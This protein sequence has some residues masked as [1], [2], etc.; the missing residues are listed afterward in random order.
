MSFAEFVLKKELS[1]FTLQLANPRNVTTSE[2][3]MN[4]KMKQ[5]YEIIEL[6]INAFVQFS[7]FFRSF[8]L[9]YKFLKEDLRIFNDSAFH[10]CVNIEP[11]RKVQNRTYLFLL[12][13]ALKKQKRRNYK[14]LY[15]CIIYL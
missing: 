10:V 11:V 1:H 12:S 8:K 2:N 15:I 9:V 13:P 6:Q 3:S 14:T 7:F 4:T 5:R